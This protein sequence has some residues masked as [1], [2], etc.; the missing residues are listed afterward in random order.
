MKRGRTP[1]SIELQ[2]AQGTYR[3]DRH[4]RREDIRQIWQAR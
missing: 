4:G 3:K 1:K 2:I